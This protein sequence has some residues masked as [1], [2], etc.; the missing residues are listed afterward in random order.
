MLNH[1]EQ[2]TETLSEVQRRWWRVEADARQ[3][4]IVRAAHIQGTSRT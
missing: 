4:I 2:T 3:N 1:M